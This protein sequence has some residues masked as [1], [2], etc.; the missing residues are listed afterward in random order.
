MEHYKR[1]TSIKFIYWITQ[2]LFW[3][4]SIAALFAIAFSIGL[5]IGVFDKT[6]LHVGVPIEINVAEQG[7]AHINDTDIAV[8][9]KQMQGKIHFIDTPPF[10]GRTYGIFI[11]I[12]LS[13]TLYIFTT[14]KN[15][16]TNVYNGQYFERKNIMLLKRISYALLGSWVFTVFYAIFQKFYLVNNLEFETI[17]FTNEYNTYP[18]ILLVALLIWVL[19]HILLKGIEFKEES[20]YTI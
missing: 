13:I 19:S 3:L 1:P 2:G 9:F 16:I 12:I 15:F 6:Q 18:S 10:I 14:F 4:F 5:M 8:E 11:I 20:E 17:I 7:I